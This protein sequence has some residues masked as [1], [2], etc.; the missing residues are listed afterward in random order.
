MDSSL[1]V[2]R[3]EM[4]YTCLIDLIRADYKALLILTDLII[5]I[6][7]DIAT[8]YWLD[9]WGTIPGRGKI[10]LSTPQRPDRL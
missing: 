10:F 3:P 1:V 9:W 7:F 8:G 2:V 4:L 5:L 6:I